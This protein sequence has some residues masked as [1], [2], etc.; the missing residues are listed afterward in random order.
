VALTTID[1]V[2]ETQ[3]IWTFDQTDEGNTAAGDSGGP[4]YLD[5]GG[6]LQIASI[7]SGGTTENSE[8]GDVSFNTRVDAFADWVNAILDRGIDTGDDTGQPEDQPPIVEPPPADDNPPTDGH[9]P[10][11]PPI[12]PPGSWHP[13]VHRPGPVRH[14]GPMHHPGPARRPG[15]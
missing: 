2:S 9:P 8:L 7:T 4:G 3:I 6:K 13:P 1:A 15:S 12:E 14:P 5:T 11:V 10:V